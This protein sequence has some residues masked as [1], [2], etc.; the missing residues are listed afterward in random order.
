LEA[1]RNNDREQVLALLADTQG[2]EIHA[3]AALSV[4][5]E[6]MNRPVG[7]F[8]VGGPLLS[9]RATRMEDRGAG[10]QAWSRWQYA[11]EAKCHRTDLSQTKAG[12]QVTD[13]NLANRE[14]CGP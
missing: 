3:H 4:I 9:V 13:F 1:L 14:D 12:W 11:K 2:K 6:E 5:Q 7:D 10:K 8:G